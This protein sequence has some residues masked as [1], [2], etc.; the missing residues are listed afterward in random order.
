[1]VKVVGGGKTTVV[2]G[3]SAGGAVVGGSGAA[4]DA[5]LIVSKGSQ[6]LHVFGFQLTCSWRRSAHCKAWYLNATN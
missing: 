6:Y 2:V 5:V 3:V 1:M 4:V